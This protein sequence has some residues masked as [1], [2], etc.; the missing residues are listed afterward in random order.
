MRA[1][2]TVTL[3]AVLEVGAVSESIEVKASAA[4]LETETSSTG[5]LVTAEVLT[6][7]PTPQ[8]KLE[9]VLWYVPG[10]TSQSGSGHVAGGRDRAFTMTTDGVSAMDPGVGALGLAKNMS[11][12]EHNVEE[13]KINTTTLPAEYG[14]SGG[15]MMSVTFKSGGNQLH[16][17]AEER[18]LPA[19]FMHRRWE[20][21]QPVT[22]KT[23]YQLMSGTINGAIVIPKIY[24]GHN[25]T[26]FLAGFQRPLTKSGEPVFATV[27]TPEMLGGD[28]TF[29][30]IGN[31]IYDPAT[32]VRLADG[33]Y[34][35]SVRRQQSSREQSRPG[36]REVHELQTLV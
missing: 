20:D 31:P 9:T 13:L 6:A 35:Y 36:V 27:P 15:G 23:N 16:G 18:W 21:R 33:T 34:P 3:D 4:L 11:S 25:R 7:L 8:M 2:E 24:D 28:F 17:V 32:T 29:G 26:F 22:S 19:E 10:V 12:P 5:H 30:G 1:A 14:H